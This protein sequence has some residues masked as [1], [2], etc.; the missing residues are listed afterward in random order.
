[1]SCGLSVET[2]HQIAFLTMHGWTFS[3]YNGWTKPGFTRT[4]KKWR[5]CC[6]GCED[7]VVVETFD[8]TSEA[9]DRQLEALP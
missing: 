9:Y 5:G 1:M 6:S 3:T 2:V 4:V 8:D 7:D